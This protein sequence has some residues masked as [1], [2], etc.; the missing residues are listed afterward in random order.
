M[1]RSSSYGPRIVL[2]GSG[3]APSNSW[4]GSASHPPVPS[5]WVLGDMT[6]KIE[7]ERKGEIEKEKERR[8]ERE[9]ERRGE[10]ERR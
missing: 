2:Q 6:R 3:S 10:G 7:G 8:R 4:Y 1:V 9:R 5:Q